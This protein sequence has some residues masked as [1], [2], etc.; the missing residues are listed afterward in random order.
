[1]SMDLAL[2]SNLTKT[3]PGKPF[4]SQ[5]YI[6]DHVPGLRELLPQYRGL[7]GFDYM[8]CCVQNLRRA[9]DEGW[10]E[11]ERTVIYT[12]EGELG[13]VDM[14]LLARGQ[15]MPGQP[16]DSGAR[17]CVCDKAV[18][19]L[20]GVHIN[21]NRHT[22]EEVAANVEAETNPTPKSDTSTPA[23]QAEVFTGGQVNVSK[24]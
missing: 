16:H 15:R 13:R 23:K 1:M 6:F 7:P 17:L 22:A 8:Q 11:V 5:D 3:E 14:K 4:Q 20:T 24:P 9:Q 2:P 12:I 19:T 10:V 18:E 21:P